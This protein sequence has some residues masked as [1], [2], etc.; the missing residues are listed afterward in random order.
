M[1]FIKLNINQPQAEKLVTLGLSGRSF[2][3]PVFLDNKSSFEAPTYSNAELSPYNFIKIGAFCSIAQAKIGNVIIGRYCSIAND[4]V[5]GANE[6]PLNR[7]STSRIIQTPDLHNWQRF[8]SKPIVD[9]NKYAKPY[10]HCNP[11]TNI[12]NDVWIGQGAFI[13]AGI[14]IGNG[15]V[16]GAH[17]TVTKDVPAYAIVTGTP[18]RFQRSRFSSGI[19]EK[20]EE[21]Q[22]WKYNIYDFIDIDLSNLATALPLLEKKINSWEVEEYT[23][24]VYSLDMINGVVI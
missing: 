11:V 3:C 18:A 1:N 20:L 22:W 15:A 7:L 12:G 14:T 2:C 8:A 13:K 9:I 10:E 6:H 24:N 5:I 17:A 4:V 23:G 19:C 16:I 21:L